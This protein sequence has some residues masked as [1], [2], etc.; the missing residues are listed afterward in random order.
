[1][2]ILVIINDYYPF[3]KPTAKL[4]HRIIKN[5]S[6]RKTEVDVI[7]KGSDYPQKKIS[8]RIINYQIVD[9][10]L[11]K[12]FSIAKVFYKL[13]RKFF[14]KF[15]IWGL[16]DS[17]RLF[18]M[19][20]KLVKNNKYDLVL[21]ISGVFSAHEAATTIATKYDIPLFLYYADPFTGNWV[22][23]KKKQTFIHKVEKKW[24]AKACCVFMPQCYFDDYAK[25]FAE[26]KK[27]ITLCELPGF[28]DESEIQ[29]IDSSK[30]LNKLVVYAGDF[31]PNFREPYNFIALAKKLSDYTFLVTGSLKMDDFQLS[32]IPS[33][34]KIVK[35]LSGDEYL[36]TIGT[37]SFLYLEDN[38]F[39]NQIPY[40]TFEY[41]SANRPIIFSTKNTDSAASRLIKHVK[42][43]VIVTDVETI[44]R[45]LFDAINNETN[46]ENKLPDFY[47]KYKTNVIC[48]IIFDKIKECLENK[49][50]DYR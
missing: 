8:E 33:N 25:S 13:K 32:S 50:N 48:D 27:K 20:K 21:S 9:Y 5:F 46:L 47:I 23:R 44:N 6:N 41:I 31:F 19:A 10:D 37:A 45:G 42:N 22:L 12:G 2:K 38:Y 18:K 26:Y 24:L 1:M 14:A 34:I 43:I 49:N 11:I 40:K 28:F 7:S 36:K 17:K 4:A 3:N 39:P 29:I 16:F 30:K 15:S 35:R